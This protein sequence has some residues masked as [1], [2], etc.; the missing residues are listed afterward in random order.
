MPVAFKQLASSKQYQLA[1]A[2]FDVRYH[3]DQ[4]CIKDIVR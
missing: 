1:L 4:Q 2:P 3:C